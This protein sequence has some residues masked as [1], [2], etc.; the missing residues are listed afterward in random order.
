[1]VNGDAQPA[2]IVQGVV[3]KYPGCS[4]CSGELIRLLRL[5]G[6]VD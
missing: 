4:G 3:R 5:P 6:R 1:M 2:Q